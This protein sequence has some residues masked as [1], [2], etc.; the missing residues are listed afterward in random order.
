MNVIILGPAGCG[1][2]TLTGK[3]GEY[4]EKENY[5]V[6]FLNL[7]PGCLSLPYP[8]DYDIR[9]KF[10]VEEIMKKE[11]LGPNGAM[12]K[13]MEKLSKIKIPKYEEDY[14]LIDTPGQLE[15][16]AFHESGPKI[17]NQF[18]NLVGIFILDASIGINDLPAAYL[19]SLATSYRLGVAAINIINKVDLLRDREVEKIRDYLLNP[20][21]SKEEIK[22]EGILSDI[23]LP[24]SELL[25]KIVPAQRIPRVS[26]KTGKGFDELL[27]MLHE[28]RCACGDLT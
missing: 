19:Y 17:V 27:D 15:V 24:I 10:T 28:I 4:L 22:V 12:I 26:A 18:N 25:Q 7:D 20:A 3:F 6:K 5:S 9:E 2:S 1:K 14:V 13:A 11:G 21:T 16:F 23:Y 8:C